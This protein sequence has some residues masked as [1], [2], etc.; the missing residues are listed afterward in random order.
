MLDGGTQAAN[1]HRRANALE[2]RAL[3]PYFVAALAPTQPRRLIV[4]SYALDTIQLLALLLSTR[5]PWGTLLQSVGVPVYVSILPFWDAHVAQGYG[6]GVA[7]P[8]FVGIFF[9]LLALVYVTFAHTLLLLYC[10]AE[11]VER[12]LIR[13]NSVTVALIAGALFSPLL[14]TLTAGVVCDPLTRSYVSSTLYTSSTSSSSSRNANILAAYYVNSGVINAS[15]SSTSSQLSFAATAA[16]SPLELRRMTPV[17]PTLASLLANSGSFAAG[18]SSSSTL[19]SAAVSTTTTTLVEP[20]CWT[21]SV[22]IAQFVFGIPAIAIVVLARCVVRGITYDAAHNSQSIAARSQGRIETASTLSHALL[23]FLYHTLLPMGH[24][25]TFAGIFAL[26]MILLAGATAW[27]LPFYGRRYNAIFGT[28]RFLALAFVALY[29]LVYLEWLGAEMTRGNS[30][31][32]FGDVSAF[33]LASTSATLSSYDTLIL[34]AGC[35]LFAWLGVVVANLRVNPRCDRAVQL[36]AEGQ[37]IDDAKPPRYPFFLPL[38]ERTKQRALQTVL[39]MHETALNRRQ[40]LDPRQKAFVK[41]IQSIGVLEAF[42]NAIYIP[43]DIEVAC[44]FL[45]YFRLATNLAPS[46]GMIA[47]ASRIYSK[48]IAKFGVHHPAILAHHA[49]FVSCYTGGHWDA[50]ASLDALHRRIADGDS[51]FAIDVRYQIYKHHTEL[52]SLLNVRDNSSRKSFLNAQRLHRD[53]LNLMNVFWSHLAHDQPNVGQLATLAKAITDRRTEGSLMYERVVS[54]HA[55]V[56]VLAKYVHFLE[57]VMIEADAASHVKDV[58]ADMLDVTGGATGGAAQLLNDAGGGG[59][60]GRGG[61]HPDRSAGGGVLGHTAGAGGGAS[62]SST[63][64]FSARSRQQNTSSTIS[65]LRGTV[66]AVFL[67]LVLLLFSLAAY[68]ILYRRQEQGLYAS[69]YDTMRLRDRCQEAAAAVEGFSRAMADGT[70][71]ALHD[72][73]A[74]K[75][76]SG[77]LDETSSSSFTS[78]I[79]NPTALAAYLSKTDNGAAIQRNVAYWQTVLKNVRPDIQRLTQRLSSGCGLAGS[80][81]SSSSAEV[82][83]LWS[84]ATLQFPRAIARRSGRDSPLSGVNASANAVRESATTIGA[85]EGAVYRTTTMGAASTGDQRA[86]LWTIMSSLNTAL[87]A[88]TETSASAL[89]QDYADEDPTLTASLSSWQFNARHSVLWTL[90]ATVN[91]LTQEARSLQVY[92]GVIITAVAVVVIIVLALVYFVLSSNFSEIHAAKLATLNLFTLIPKAAVNSIRRRSAQDIEGLENTDEQVERMMGDRLGSS[93]TGAPMGASTAGGGLS[94]S[95]N[96]ASPST[97]AKAT[98][99]QQQPQN[100]SGGEMKADPTKAAVGAKD[101]PAAGDGGDATMETAE[102]GAGGSDAVDNISPSQ[103]AVRSKLYTAVS[104][105]SDR[106]DL[107]NKRRGGVGSGGAGST[108][109]GTASQVKT[110]FDMYAVYGYVDENDAATAAGPGDES[111]TQQQQQQLLLKGA[112]ASAA[113]AQKRGT[114]GR[115]GVSASL[116]LQT[117]WQD[118]LTGGVEGADVPTGQ[119]RGTGDGGGS[120]GGVSWE[121][122]EGLLLDA[123]GS[124]GDAAAGGGGPS[125]GSVTHT[126]FMTQRLLS[127]LH[128]Q[129]LALSRWRYVTVFC[130]LVLLAL[131]SLAFGLVFVAMQHLEAFAIASDGRVAMSRMLVAD[132]RMLWKLKDTAELVTMRPGDDGVEQF[133]EMLDVAEELQRELTVDMVLQPRLTEGQSRLFAT[134]RRVYLVLVNRLNAA[135]ALACRAVGQKGVPLATAETQRNNGDADASSTSSIPS[136]G[137]SVTARCSL[138]GHSAVIGA[139]WDFRDALDVVSRL[140]AGDDALGRAFGPAGSAEGLSATTAGDV[141]STAPRCAYAVDERT[142]LE[143]GS[144]GDL[145]WP[146]ISEPSVVGAASANPAPPSSSSCASQRPFDEE[147]LDLST[148]NPYELTNQTYDLFLRQSCE[149]L[150]TAQEA[151]FG[152]MTTMLVQLWM[153]QMSALRESLGSGGWSEAELADGNGLAADHTMLQTHQDRQAMDTSEL[154]SIFEGGPSGD[155]DATESSGV[156]A[157]RNAASN[158]AFE[159]AEGGNAVS[160]NWLLT[161]IGA[162]RVVFVTLSL[163]SASAILE[164]LLGFGLY[165]GIHAKRARIAQLR[166][167]LTSI[168]TVGGDVA[169]AT[170]A[171]SRTSGDNSAPTNRRSGG[172]RLM[173]VNASWVILSLLLFTTLGGLASVSAA[174]DVNSEQLQKLHSRRLA[175]LRV[176]GSA[177]SAVDDWSSLSRRIVVSHDA[178]ALLRFDAAAQHDSLSRKIVAVFKFLGPA[179]LQD[180][181]ALLGAAYELGDF[182][183]IAATVTVHKVVAAAAASLTNRSAPASLL[184]EFV[185]PDSCRRS[186]GS[187]E[188]AFLAVAPDWAVNSSSTSFMRWNF[189]SQPAAIRLQLEFPTQ[190]WYSTPDRDVSASSSLEAQTGLAVELVTGPYPL[191]V[192]STI[193]AH[194]VR[195]L[196]PVDTQLTAA[197]DAAQAGLQAATIVARVTLSTSFVLIAALVYWIW[198][199]LLP[200]T[201]RF[202]SGGEDGKGVGGG[203]NR[204]SDGNT[205]ETGDDGTAGGGADFS[206]GHGGAAVRGGPGGTS[207]AAAVGGGGGNGDGNSSAALVPAGGAGSNMLH[208]ARHGSIVA[209][210]RKS[211]YALTFV[212]ALFLAVFVVGVVVFVSSTVIILTNQGRATL[213]STYV[214]SAITEA[215]HAAASVGGATRRWNNASAVAATSSSSA[216]TTATTPEGFSRRRAPL[217][218]AIANLEAAVR[219]LVAADIEDQ[220]MSASRVTVPL[221]SSTWSASAYVSSDTI[222]SLTATTSA[223]GDTA[224]STL[225]GRATYMAH[226]FWCG[227]NATSSSTV[228]VDPVVSPQTPSSRRFVPSAAPF[229]DILTQPFAVSVYF[230]ADAAVRQLLALLR[231][232]YIFNEAATVAARDASAGTAP[233]AMNPTT[234]AALSAAVTSTLLSSAET[235]HQATALVDASVSLS[236]RSLYNAQTSTSGLDAIFYAAV[237]VVF[238]AILAIFLFVFRPMIDDLSREELGTMIILRMIPADVQQSVPAIAEFLNS[239]TVIQDMQLQEVAD[240]MEDLSTVPTISIDHVGTILRFSRAA[241]HVFQWSRADVIGCNVSVLMPPRVAALHDGFLVDYYNTG[242]RRVIGTAR[243]V[244][245]MRRDG[246][247][248]PAELLVREIRLPNGEPTY[249]GTVRDITN[250]IEFERTI[251]LSKAVSDIATVPIVV[252][253]SYGKVMRFN[254]AAESVF[255]YTVDEMMGANVKVLMPDDTAVM[256]DEYLATYRRTRQRHIIGRKRRIRCKRSDGR[257]FPAVISVVEVTRASDDVGAGGATGSLFVGYVEDYSKHIE[258]QMATTVNDAVSTTSPVPMVTITST[259][260]VETWSPAA[261][262]TFRIQPADILG[263]NVKLIMPEAVAVKHDGYLAAYMRD[264]RTTMIGTTRIVKARRR[265]EEAGGWVVFPVRVSIQVLQRST[266]ASFVAFLQDITHVR[267]LEMDNQ[268]ASAVLTLSPTAIIGADRIGTITFFSAA[269]ARVFGYTAEE[270]VGANLKLLMPKRIADVHDGYLS[271]YARTG[272]KHVVDTTRVVTARLKTGR[273]IPV[274]I[275]IKDANLLWS[276]QTG[277]NNEGKAGVATTAYASSVLRRSA[278]TDDQAALLLPIRGSHGDESAAVAPATASSGSNKMAGGEVVLQ[279]AYIGY[280]ISREDRGKAEEEN[281]VGSALCQLSVIPM[282]TISHIGDIL[283]CSDSACERFGYVREELM[284]MNVRQLMPDTVARVHDGYLQKYQERLANDGE[285]AARKVSTILGQQRRIIAKTRD[286]TYFPA[287]IHIRDIHIDGLPTTFVGTIRDETESVEKE[288]Q[289]HIADAITSTSTTPLICISQL[290]QITVF[291]TAAEK[292]F[293]YLAAD[294]V[295]K[296]VKMLMPPDVAAQHDGFL[297][298]YCKT[299]IKHVI[300]SS[301]EV[302]ARH[303][304]GHT[305]HV[306]ILVRELVQKDALGRE[307]VEFIGFVRNL[308]QQYILLQANMINDVVSALS[309]EPIVVISDKGLILEFNEAAEKCFG[310]QRDAVMN[311]N[312]KLLMPDEIASQ[313]DGYLLKYKQTGRKTAIDSLRKV[314]ARASDG[315]IFPCELAVKE[316]K[317]EGAQSQYISYVRDTTQA[318]AL[319][320]QFALN[321]ATVDASPTALIVINNMG[322]ITTF[323]R[324]AGDTFGYQKVECLGKNLK[325]LMPPDIA[326]HHDEYLAA[327]RRTKI[328]TVVDQSRRVRGQRK[329]GR[330]F[331]LE[332]TVREVFDGEGSSIFVGYAKDMT[333]E[334]QLQTASIYNEAVCACSPIAIIV[335]DYLG[336][337]MSFSKAAERTFGYSINDALEH[338]VKMVTPPEIA[339]QHDRFLSNYLQTGVKSVIDDPNRKVTARRQDGKL[340]PARIFVR[341]VKQAGWTHPVFVGYVT[342]ISEELA[343]EESSKE[344]LAVMDL[345]EYAIIGISIRGMISYCNAATLQLFGH[346]DR[347]SLVGQNVKMLMPDGIAANHDAYLERFLATGVKTV[348]DSTRH[349]TAKRKNGTMFR[350]EIAVREVFVAGLEA[351]YIGYVKDI[352]DKLKIKEQSLISEALM[353]LSTHPIVVIDSMGTI[354][355]VSDSVHSLFGF[356]VAEIVGENVRRLMPPQIAVAHDGY[357]RTYARTRVKHVIDSTRVVEGRTKDGYHFPCEIGVKELSHEGKTYFAGF[358]RD[359]RSDLKVGGSAEV[360]AAMME[361]APHAVIL[362]DHTGTIIKFNQATL[363][364][365]H[366]APGTNLVGFNV[367][368]LMPPETAAQHDSYLTRYKETKRKTVI[369]TTR[370]VR[371]QRLD[372]TK[373]SFPVEISVREVEEDGDAEPK[374]LGYI[375]SLEEQR[376]IELAHNTALATLDLSSYAVVV[377]EEAGKVLQMSR[378]GLEMFDIAKLEDIVG[379]NVKV[380]MPDN[381]AVHHDGYLADYRNT[382]IKHV[383]D[384]SREL[385]AMTFRAP[386]R[387][388][389]IR[390]HAKELNFNTKGLEKVFVAFISAI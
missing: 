162:D 146:S 321:D 62:G 215:M 255:G 351:Q 388:F 30:T 107:G 110:D 313:H 329:N 390:L 61:N 276:E 298:A 88:L 172:K 346:V 113:A 25:Q 325:M 265:D 70:A 309:L 92:G 46:P 100:G 280:V 167:M 174:Y 333:Q 9:V 359:L 219:Q 383:L 315:R 381:I 216:T 34:A 160:G 163:L 373:A 54:E 360:N 322:T 39:L 217:R 85:G 80:S 48:G 277:G 267:T 119:R 336:T 324:S 297:R 135:V 263:R 270:A 179:A 285:A 165:Y 37:P 84:L 14:H 264:G 344:G 127:Q 312:V 20:V 200:T 252:M 197:W 269:A 236:S 10:V 19:R 259:G 205:N 378:A 328:K 243:K 139:S 235:L 5:W 64:S 289:K 282:V 369:D 105:H 311:R 140:L 273:E 194:V 29:M 244:Q 83:R 331:P 224:K 254:R 337:I 279:T 24:H 300:D 65:R 2:T 134:S 168:A 108:G 75:T 314:K 101:T 385:T 245:A 16:S 241:E 149:Q 58:I 377:I 191:H 258:F 67:V 371:G 133:M 193:R 189:S 334:L 184:P 94:S 98:T 318:D 72:L 104:R 357:L 249:F 268:I 164:V 335:I 302:V 136:G 286:E 144:G 150:R 213:R 45:R 223:N 327:Y 376:A 185:N 117:R 141:W 93:I 323:S 56:L 345:C 210:N 91:Q 203:A 152:R 13:F 190:V 74:T 209:Y 362:I 15:S 44:R 123:P 32:Y 227:L 231:G 111:T 342:D 3:F 171:G 240:A 11:Q 257:Y 173:T 202:S 78:E 288:S 6:I 181:R 169:A 352:T 131:L 343:V 129:A 247:M 23:V 89:L 370:Q 387:S 166:A 350:A 178:Q 317:K 228:V 196:A 310:Y 42:I 299:G 81:S 368:I 86:S 158:S 330:S 71:I 293:G 386:R 301:R 182:L 261:V 356:T 156:F 21:S 374:F 234:S 55:D 109:S 305:F 40:D 69:A 220:M 28:S 308:S 183:S 349:V 18:G 348:V 51:A 122:E 354:L 226:A 49:Q 195:T 212:G 154:S 230:G 132:E 294:V 304:K 52:S 232:L 1:H 246:T 307:T 76:A 186:I 130:A 296:N 208:S 41:G 26:L 201:A 38:D 60:G 379:R 118:G 222:S 68:G 250:E 382:G 102:G 126:K 112:E 380:L 316:L 229:L 159:S 284:G 33:S 266:G 63:S 363:Q 239:G 303:A 262:N 155:S 364:L 31:T 103:E 355:K 319:E 151:A 238:I 248:I 242:I 338:N 218:Q 332:I 120:G 366:A 35:A 57:H 87:A 251:A 177:T 271:A 153:Q 73:L 27:Y 142:R 4:A 66:S 7:F 206:T 214:S 53:A 211:K 291:S 290:G 121:D 124:G 358:I 278:K 99:D 161:W 372:K 97:N 43:S 295:G 145:G 272:V 353:E 128:G 106:A 147:L 233:A 275:R 204:D 77:A 116:N 256:H 59:G 281:V 36:A 365:F 341:E 198:T 138:A 326:V 82:R 12:I 96:A 225:F 157:L 274:E 17:A 188:A 340:F 253:D 22:T 375:R 389:A 90:N 260:I 47:F 8:A 292:D 175:L 384:T 367:N 199:R 283:Y 287:S 180:V 361:I 114:S 176:S 79:L 221:T 115:E 306:V 347:S 148:R 125:R 237:A 339:Q 192:L 207:S 320:E 143:A 170:A 50:L 187:R 95:V 137:L